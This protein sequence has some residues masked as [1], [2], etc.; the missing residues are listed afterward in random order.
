MSTVLLCSLLPSCSNNGAG[1]LPIQNPG[2]GAITDDEA[3]HL[4]HQAMTHY[5]SATTYQLVPYRIERIGTQQ[6]VARNDRDPH[7][8]F[9]LWT[10]GANTYEVFL[11]VEASQ[12]RYE[13]SRSK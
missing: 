10:D 12:V 5:D 11:Q 3:I 9:I 1:T 8:V 7:R 6:Y 2:T 4:S 13:I